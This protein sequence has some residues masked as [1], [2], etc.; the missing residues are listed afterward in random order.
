MGTR[1]AVGS[2]NT[3]FEAYQKAHRRYRLANR[4]EYQLRWSWFKY[5]TFAM[6]GVKVAVKKCDDGKFAIKYGTVVLRSDCRT[7]AECMATAFNKNGHLTYAFYYPV[8][9]AN[10]SDIPFWGET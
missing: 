2:G 10:S 6:N 1:G 4:I 5:A 9:P 7:I 3:L 8:F